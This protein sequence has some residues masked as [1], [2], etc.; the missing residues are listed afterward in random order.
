MRFPFFPCR[1]N[2]MRAVIQRVSC[3]SVA[4]A[5][6]TVGEIGLGF[7]VLL[8]VENN[9]TDTDLNFILNKTIGL[10]VFDDAQGKMNLALRDV[11]GQM[12][13]VSQFTLLGD[14]RKG[15]RP[16][17]TRAAPPEIANVM[18][19]EFVRQVIETGIEVQ[20]G[21]FG[22]DMQVNLTND[23]P[24]TIWLNSR[25]LNSRSNT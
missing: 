5:D 8:G 12:L 9:D 1:A 21:Q 18:Y 23:G 10:R 14:T 24:V 22:A 19:E 13:V 7:L 16:S 3:A 25:N 15:M 4:V 11:G 20:T 2:N 17:F 6:Q